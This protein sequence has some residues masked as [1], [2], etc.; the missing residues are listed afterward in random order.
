MTLGN[1]CQAFERKYLFL[2]YS[3]PSIY[4]HLIMLFKPMGYI[5]IKNSILL[6]YKMKRLVTDTED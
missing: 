5:T 3:Y 4:A 2:E 6:V 1:S